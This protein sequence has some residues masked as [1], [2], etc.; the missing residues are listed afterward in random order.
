[1][2][3]EAERATVGSDDDSAWKVWPG[4]PGQSAR[5]KP[6]PQQ[7]ERYEAGVRMPQPQAGFRRSAPQQLLLWRQG[8]LECM[9]VPRGWR[10]LTAI[11]AASRNPKCMFKKMCSN[12]AQPLLLQDRGF[13]EPSNLASGGRASVVLHCLPGIALV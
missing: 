2:Q 10:R 7:A 6:T 11:T 1:M 5:V 4:L 9:T 3:V 12:L 8:W 13:D